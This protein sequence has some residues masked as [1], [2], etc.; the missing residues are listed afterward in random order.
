MIYSNKGVNIEVYCKN[1]QTGEILPEVKVG[2]SIVWVGTPGL[3]FAVCV[4]VDWK[5]AVGVQCIQVGCSVGE[6]QHLASSRALQIGR[7]LHE[8]VFLFLPAYSN[9]YKTCC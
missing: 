4:A 1:S 2:N 7:S 6:F 3:E 9:G 5:A 8:S